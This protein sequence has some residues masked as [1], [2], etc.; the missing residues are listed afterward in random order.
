MCFV[1]APLHCVQSKL[2]S[3]FFPV[4]VSTAFPVDGVDF[5]MGNSIAGGRV[6][7]VPEAVNVPIMVSE[8]DVVAQ[9]LPDFSIS[10][11]TKTQSCQQAHKLDLSDSLLAS[12][13]SKNKLPS[14][15]IP[16][17]PQF[18]KNTKLRDLQVQ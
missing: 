13:L 14:S 15:S 7:P 8:P 12:V 1:P 6:Y 16:L 11:M 9:N 17:G 3:G 18:K 5:I 4:A 10:V 2:V